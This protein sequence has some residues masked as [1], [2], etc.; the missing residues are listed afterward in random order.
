MLGAGGEGGTWAGRGGAN[1]ACACGWQS[2]SREWI[3]DQW[4][5]FWCAFKLLSAAIQ[6]SQ[7]FRVI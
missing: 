4:M 3:S 1:V 2:G 6:G 7:G 5:R